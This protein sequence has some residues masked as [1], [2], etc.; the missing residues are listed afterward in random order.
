M[1]FTALVFVN[2]GGFVWES[3]TL[4]DTTVGPAL[5]PVF[6]VGMD[7][8]FAYAYTAILTG[9]GALFYVFARNPTVYRTQAALLM[10]GATVPISTWPTRWGSRGVR[11]RDST[12]H[13]SVSS[14][15]RGSSG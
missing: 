15:R 5:E 2:P 9:L 13:R 10:T 1:V 6:G 11:F 14:S 7:A 4:A 8:H 12:R 3:L